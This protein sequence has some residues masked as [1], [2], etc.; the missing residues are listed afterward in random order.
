MTPNAAVLRQ[1]AEDDLSLDR[2]V[3]KG[4]RINTRIEQ[5][6]LS[7]DL[8]RTIEGASTLS[9]TVHDPDRELLTSPLLDG[10]VDLQLDH[11][12]FRLVKVGKSG[13][14]LSLTFED[15]AVA[16]MRRYRK[17]RKATRGKT[18]RAEFARQLV[19]EVKPPIRFVCPEL[20]KTRPIKGKRDREPRAERDD[21]RAPG[22]A[23]GVTLRIKGAVADAEQ[24]R[25]IERVLDVAES[26]DAG[27][28]ATLALAEACIVESLFR[29]QPGG[30][31][32]SRGILQLITR[33]AAGLHVDPLD[34]EACVRLFL[35]HGFTGAGGA[36][37]LARRH[38]TWN[39]GQV[40]Q[41]VQGSGYPTRY[42]EYRDE[43]ERIVA[44]YGG[45]TGTSRTI[46]VVKPYEFRR[47]EPGGKRENTWDCLGRLAD[48]AG[49]RRF[50]VAD[51]LH[52]ISEQDLFRSRPLMTLR[53][54]DPEIDTIDFE[55]DRG[56]KIAE[57]HVA[58]EAT[59]WFAP[60]GSVVLVD[61]LGHADGRWLVTTI[62]R[63]LADI[64]TEITLRKPIPELP[65]PAAETATRTIGGDD[66][67]SGGSD[68]A[69]DV[70]SGTL[71]D[72]VVAA[73]E[74]ALRR[75]GD[76]HY[77]Q[78][79]PVLPSLSTRPVSGHRFDCSWFTTLCYK[80]AG[81]PDPNGG[82]YSAGY[83]GTLRAHGRRTASPRPGDM[84]HY[85][86]GTGA[87]VA[88]YIGGGQCIGIGSE[89]VGLHRHPAL[90]RSDF[91][92]YWTY[93]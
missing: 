86:G 74:Q 42:E 56:H 55:Y 9:L 10:Y 72:K 79:G 6:V 8:E 21:R 44:A 41:A 77:S 49:W 88:L 73:A 65:E 68:P 47:G 39:A 81:A 33:T 32:S 63:G 43:A 60:P 48:E 51:A 61:G 31:G 30:E 53:E 57:M 12:W 92:G 38:P 5:S 89:A 14:V 82:N 4:K 91:A 27:P 34:I 66:F 7:A 13:D 87:H 18:T 1:R 22:L 85:G 67:G 3:L 64:H 23:R 76:Y 35:T 75:R 90:Y 36:I 62:R 29:N 80:A 2:L 20:H 26:H 69:L 15:R 71:R 19:R 54:S 58:C 52:F 93:L 28:K 70:G 83:T 40:A 16:L 45:S 84:A 50:M 59:R 25:N 46:T 17:P 24:R 11:L 37:A 78:A